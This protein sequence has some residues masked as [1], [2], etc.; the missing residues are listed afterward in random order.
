MELL[1]ALFELSKDLIP[2]GV[3]FSLVLAVLIGAH[4][5]LNWR[6]RSVLGFRFR[7]QLFMLALSFLGFLAILLSL[8]LT[9]GMKGQLLSFIGI[10]L[11]GVLALSATTFVGNILAG[12]MLR[13]MRNFR[14][15]DFIRVG[16][17]F[18]RVSEL[19]LF[20][21]EVQTESRDLT[22]LPNLYV[23][24]NP[25][26]VI[27]SSGT[28]V[29]AEISLGYDV[30]HGKVTEVLELAAGKAGL[31]DPFVH[32]LELGN[33]AI[34]YRVSGL[35]VEVKN[36]LTTRSGLKGMI[37]DECHSNGIE[38]VS[39]SF[40]NQRVIPLDQQVVPELTLEQAGIGK[41]STIESVAFDKADKAESLDKLR[42]RHAR[43]KEELKQLQKEA[44]EAEDKEQRGT[45]N[46]RIEAIQLQMERLA[47][48]V[49]EREQNKED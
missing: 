21:V 6:Y 12:L 9:E 20:H 46:K 39:P 2:L 47:E 11:S 43:L 31:E 5:F 25:V 29:T 24:T 15:G 3:T 35:L 30:P 17:H 28:L 36:L 13:V 44:D 34:S 23:A 10:L 45:L 1:R 37:L 16:E 48:F 22:T 26:K 14:A 38:I 41:A 7:F 4:Y 33:Y 32:I 49:A 8:P 18:G 42:Q 19:E 27:R 40:V